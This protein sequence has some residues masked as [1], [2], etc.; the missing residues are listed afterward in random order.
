MRKVMA[1]LAAA[2]LAGA[3]TGAQPAAAGAAVQCEDFGEGPTELSCDGLSATTTSGPA[4]LCMDSAMVAG[5]MSSELANGAKVRLLIHR[6]QACGSEW[7]TLQVLNWP[8]EE[9]PAP[10]IRVSIARANEPDVDSLYEA[11]EV[12]TD[13]GL[14]LDEGGNGTAH[15]P[16]LDARTR[17]L[18]DMRHLA[19]VVR[20]GGLGVAARLETGDLVHE[21]MPCDGTLYLCMTPRAW[22]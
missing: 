20:R 17:D 2:V 16:M 8:T 15:S 11:A 6:S 12:E 1:L 9:E 7:T 19:K 3:V 18:L 4:G 21:E 22:P 5:S 13:G 10:R 14:I